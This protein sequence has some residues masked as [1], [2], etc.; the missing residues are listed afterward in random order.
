MIWRDMQQVKPN[1]SKIWHNL[2]RP[3]KVL[4]ELTMCSALEQGGYFSGR[5][6]VILG[7]VFKLV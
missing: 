5:G 2:G 4:A 7:S 6:L 3:Q 1:S